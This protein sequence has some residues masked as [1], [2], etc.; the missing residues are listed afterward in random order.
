MAKETT[1]KVSKTAGQDVAETKSAKTTK[2]NSEKTSTTKTAAKK[3]T[4]TTTTKEQTSK[5]KVKPEKEVEVVKEDTKETKTITPTK[6]QNGAGNFTIGKL[7]IGLVAGAM[8]LSMAFGAT[9]LIVGLTKNGEQGKSAYEI[10]VENGFTG[11]EAEWLESLKGETGATGAAGATGAT[12]ATGQ[13]GSVGPQGVQGVDGQSV[14]IDYAGNVWEG[15]TKTGVSFTL[16][17]DN[18][19]FDNT[20]EITKV[21]S[22]HFKPAYV[23]VSENQ[24]ALMSYYKETAKVTLY[25]GIHINTLSVVSQNAGT[26]HVGVAKVA[27]VVNGRLTGASYTSITT[28]YNIVEGVN[29]LNV[30]LDVAEDETVVLGG[31]GST[32]K[33]Y[34]TQNIPLQDEAGNFALFN[35][36]ANQTVLSKTGVNDDTLAIKIDGKSV[37]FNNVFENITNITCDST[38]NDSAAPFVYNNRELFAGKTITQLGMYVK[39]LGAAVTQDQTMTVYIV[40]KDATNNYRN[41]TPIIVTVPA[42]EFYGL[43]QSS[44]EKWVYATNFKDANGKPLNGITL[45]ENQT[46]AFGAS[47]G[48]TINWGYSSGKLSEYGFT[49]YNGT[50]GNANL[51]FDIVV[52]SESGLE[53]QLKI[54]NDKEESAVQTA[55]ET[56]LKQVLSG[57]NLSILGDSISTFPGW[58]NNAAETNSTIGSNALYY[59]GS[60]YITDVNQTYWKQ[61]A[62]KTNMNVLVD[63]AWSGDKVT[64]RGQTRCEQLHD[65]TGN[66]DNGVINPDVIIV[67]LGINDFDGSVAVDTFITAYNTMIEKITTKYASAD[68][69]VC[70]L[71]PNKTRVDGAVMQQYNTAIK[72]A[73]TTYGAT[74]VDFYTDSGITADNCSLYMGDSGA[75]HPNVDGMTLMAN[76]IWN[77]L[78]N[79]YVASLNN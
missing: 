10:A 30:N 55:K 19:I 38:V 4:K 36:E 48:D 5:P 13:Q 56:A 24:I 77:T 18:A 39:S 58:S 42:S 68:V 59:T 2:S 16:S 71:V 47:S 33:L 17:S 66:Q 44:I 72:N 67:Y 37:E 57:Q 51:I 41:G 31:G 70:T 9:G 49:T 23:D 69:F 61:V 15:T 12:G 34:V 78:Y 62:N 26:L 76:T 29:E 20:L 53:E 43:T 65:D 64:G 21:M 22:R 63:N 28:N 8:G 14:Y 6:T 7:G 79:K 40:D 25:S 1:K 50:A 11:T 27:D 74:V 45:T 32:A 35:G 52:K 60:N 3:E 46:L 54:I 75:L 73:A